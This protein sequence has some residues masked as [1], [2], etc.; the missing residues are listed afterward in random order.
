[1]EIVYTGED[2]PE[3]FS[4][5]IF[6]AGPSLRPEQEDEMESWRKAALDILRD[7]GFDGV[8]FC[9]ENKDGKFHEDFDYEDQVSWEEKYLN[10]ADCIVFWVPRNLDLDDKGNPKLPAFTTNVEFGAWA[11]SGKIVFG[12]PPEA[13]KNDYLKHYAK[14]YNAPVGSS[15][16]ETLE[17]ALAKLNDGAER[18]GGERYVPLFIWNQPSFQSWYKAQTGAG[19]RLE[20]AKLLFNFRPRFKDFVFLWILHVKVYVSSEDRVKDNEFVMARPDISSVCLY[21]KVSTG[22]PA[23]WKD[24]EIVLVREFRS[25]ASTENGFVLELPGGSSL[26]ESNPEEVAAEEVH[27][28]MGLYI[29]PARLHSY[30]SRQLAATFSAHKSNLFAAEITADEIEWLK[31]QKD[32]AHGKEEDS[33]RTFIEIHSISQLINNESVDWTTLGQILSVISKL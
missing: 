2:M 10:V 11:D 24:I 4:K 6:L 33:E 8:V 23:A 17:D 29:E 14:Q 31:S 18:T 30:G 27:E 20:E 32:I 9:P 1:M 5:S 26:K 3:K 22:F 25:P 21:H 28:E 16:T 12:A 13:P 7:K 15:L 19:N